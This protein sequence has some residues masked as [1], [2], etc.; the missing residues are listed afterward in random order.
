MAYWPQEGSLKR[1]ILSEADN[2]YNLASLY[3]KSVL[4]N[5]TFLLW[6]R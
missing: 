4:G 3:H 2:P 5:G 1:N 6:T